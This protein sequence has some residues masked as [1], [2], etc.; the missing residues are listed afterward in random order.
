MRL[1][2][3]VL[4]GFLVL[5]ALG[6]AAPG[7]QANHDVGD[8]QHVYVCVSPA[9]EAECRTLALASDD[10]AGDLAVS[11]TGNATGSL[12][13]APFGD[14]EGHN[15]GLSGTGNASGI[16]AASGTGTCNGEGGD[17]AL[18]CAHVAPDDATV[19]DELVREP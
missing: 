7:A 11:V 14:A 4:V 17:S 3:T 8:R 13:V 5:G 18:P 10:A 16:A 12:A 1:R 19:P 6:V 15:A 2:S 9:S